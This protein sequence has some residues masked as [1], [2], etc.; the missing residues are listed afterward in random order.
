MTNDTASTI[1]PS[2]TDYNNETMPEIKST[3]MLYYGVNGFEITW[4]YLFTHLVLLI[5]A[6][7]G[8]FLNTVALKIVSIK[9]PLHDASHNF[10]SHLAMSDIF[11]GIICIYTVLYN[12]IHYKNYYECALRTGI[13]TC[14]NLNSSIHL[15][16]LTFDRYFKIMY[17]YKYVQYFHNEKRMKILS[18]CAWLFAGILGLLPIFGWR[19]P[20]INGTTYCS[21]FGVLDRRYLM[22]VSS[23]FFAIML[24]MFYCY[25]NIICVA[26]NQRKNVTA[27]PKDAKSSYDHRNTKALWWAPTKT[28]IILITFYSCCWMPTGKTFLETL[29]ILNQKEILKHVIYRLRYKHKEAE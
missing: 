14:M 21:Y 5:V 28:V 22:L 10:I 17:P 7:I 23:L 1:V 25:I 12:L 11:I 2:L 6:G 27:T 4:I 26:W 29:N 16:F 19:R 15:L 13:A 9:S 24:T 8:I 3:S 20:P 18:R